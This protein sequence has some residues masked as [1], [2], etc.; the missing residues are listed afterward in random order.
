[1]RS[2][3]RQPLGGVPVGVLGARPRQTRS[4]PERHVR[5]VRV[6]QQLGQIV[7]MR[8]DRIRVQLD[9]S[10][11]VD[12]EVDAAAA[13]GPLAA[14]QPPGEKPGSEQEHLDHRDREPVQERHAERGTGGRD[15]EQQA[16]HRC[17][18]RTDPRRGEDGEHRDDRPDSGDSAEEGNRREPDIGA[19]AP[20][21]EVNRRAGDQPG[22]AVEDEEHDRL[23][24]RHG[25]D[26]LRAERP[27]QLLGQGTEDAWMQ[28]EREEQREPDQRE[29]RRIDAP[30]PGQAHDED[31]DA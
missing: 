13:R 30:H 2:P 5:R 26:R 12:V 9:D 14:R 1:M 6:Q 29:Q 19:E 3:G 16:V 7:E 28:G 4:E 24:E 18:A 21:H 15:R 11:V 27:Q 22:A 31:D 17:L 25:L 20:Q 8:L 23:S 10:H